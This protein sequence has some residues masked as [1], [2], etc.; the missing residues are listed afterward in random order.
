MSDAVT[1]SLIGAMATVVVSVVNMILAISTRD[2]GK[3]NEEHLVALKNQTDGI[4]DQLVKVTG[5]A[6]F[7]KGVKSETDKAK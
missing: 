6:E 1:I 3:R 7:A 2:R 4:S 5:E